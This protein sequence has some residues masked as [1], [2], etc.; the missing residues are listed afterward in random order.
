MTASRRHALLLPLSMALLLFPAGTNFAQKAPPP[1]QPNPQAP[2]LRPVVPL[3]MQRGT[4]LELT[5]TG[6]NLAEPTALWTSFPAKVTFPTDA[7]NGKDNAKLRVRLEVPADAPLGFHSL[8]L[9]TARGISNLR[10]FCIDELPQVMETDSNRSKSTAQAV[11]V[12]CVVVGKADAEVNDYFKISVKAG[13]RVSF[14]VLGRRLGSLFDPQLTLFDT[15]TGH[16][17]PGGHSNDAP[18][19]QT[20]PRLTYTF[21]EAG[22]YVVEIRDVTYRG[23][24]DFYYRLR[25]GDFPCATAPV[26]MAARLG[27]QVAVTFAGPNVEGVAPIEV[28]VPNDP[29]LDTIWLA[30]K[31]P[32]G[33][34]G[35]PVALAVSDLEETT[36]QEPNNELAKA[37]RLPVPG[38]VTGRFQEKGDIDHYVFTAK[39]GQRYVLD[40][41]THELYSPTEVYFVVLDAKGAQ[42]AASNPMAGAR[43]DFTAP[44]DGDFTVRVEHLHY[45]GGPSEVYRLAVTPYE[46]GFDLA[47]QLDR[48]DVKQG[49]TLNLPILLTRRDFTGPVEVSV[50][51]APGL[52]GQVT[53]PG[54]GKPTPPNQPAATL[55]VI[56]STDLPVGAYEFRVQ[57]RATINGK[58]VVRYASVRAPVTQSLAGLPVPPRQTFTAIGLAV[59]EREPFALAAKFAEASVAPGKPATL[60]VTATRIPGFEAEIDVT[61]AGLPAN[62]APA[63][64]PQK[65]PAKANEVKATIAPVAA[66]PAGSFN[67]TVTGKAKHQGRDHTVTAVVPL[68]VKK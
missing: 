43:I 36:E 51:E 62:V 24:D 53:I 47:L 46:P 56:A 27:G 26:P 29:A 52:S 37:N 20:D 14:E 38:A 59:L 48:F 5:L 65:I 30:P 63:A 57:G 64:A 7:N 25:I 66:A 45:W 2:V 40:V 8:R 41:V 21:K 42:L 17:L 55:P 4:T 32:S 44:A 6:S 31:G 68:V 54:G 15:R 60:T 22:D 11:P 18:G 3:G 1:G 49:G 28:A 9:A 13:Q 12:P 58:S 67:V 10:L 16:E 23:G 34:H 35:W 61:I 50:I 39:K 33:L 19:L